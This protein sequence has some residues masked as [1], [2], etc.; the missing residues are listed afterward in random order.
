MAV[1]HGGLV[2]LT[3]PGHLSHLAAGGVVWEP[4]TPVGGDERKKR[5]LV[6]LK[7]HLQLY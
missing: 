1:D 4:C 7:N 6:C 3:A 5:G 2:R